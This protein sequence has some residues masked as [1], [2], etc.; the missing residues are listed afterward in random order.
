MEEQNNQQ[1]PQQAAPQVKI[2]QNDYTKMDEK[3]IATIKTSAIWAAVASAIT[4]LAGMIASYYLV[5]SLYG[6]MM[7]QYSQYFG[8]A[9]A[10]QMINFG[11]LISAIISGAIG[12]VVVG[13]VIAKFY[14]IFVGWQKKYLNG[15]LDSFFKIL[16][17]PSVAGFVISLVLGGALSMLS[18]AFTVFIITIVADL[19][20][21]YIYAKMMDKAVGK[22]YKQV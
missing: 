14:P 7:G 19:A 18:S 10:P 17:W 4:S 20:A 9:Y 2:P 1:A 16:F 22:Y 3:T 15:K 12:G 6:G 13:W 21:S 8:Q 11:A 5:R